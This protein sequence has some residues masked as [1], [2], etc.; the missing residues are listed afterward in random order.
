MARKK[1]EASLKDLEQ[2]VKELEAGDLPL[3]EAIKRFE[4]GMALSKACSQMLD[5]TEQKV[6]QLIK[7]GEDTF[8]EQD[9]DNRA[10]KAED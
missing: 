2:I 7:D 5:E 6:S 4:N 10:S 1:F 3:E 9:F 8:R